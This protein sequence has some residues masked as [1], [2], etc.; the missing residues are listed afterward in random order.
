MCYTWLWTQDRKVWLTFPVLC[1]IIKSYYDNIWR[2]SLVISCLAWWLFVSF[3]YLSSI[4]KLHI[5]H[6]LELFKVALS[7]SILICFE[8]T[9]M[10]CFELTLSISL[11][12]FISSNEMSIKTSV[13]IYVQVAL[14]SIDEKKT[15]CSVQRQDNWHRQKTSK[16]VYIIKRKRK[17]NGIQSAMSDERFWFSSRASFI[18]SCACWRS[19]FCS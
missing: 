12:H 17:M 7:L 3:F 8:F 13:A 16:S 4:F 5:F 19:L 1:D 15:F 6:C 18:H 9:S 11:K 2:T 14:L 10:S